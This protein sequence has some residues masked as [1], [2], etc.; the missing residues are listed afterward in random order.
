MEMEY[1]RIDSSFDIIYEQDTYEETLEIVK[2]L[3]SKLILPGNKHGVV[4]ATKLANDLN[5]LCNS[6]ENLDAMTLKHEMHNRIAEKGLRS[7][8][9]KLVSSVEEAIEFYD[10]ESLGEVVLKPIFSAGSINAKIC[11]NKQ[12]MVDYLKEQFSLK[13]D[14]GL[15]NDNILVQERINGDEYLVNT[16]S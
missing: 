1:E 9:G 7:I 13:D 8:R 2:K 15:S 14:F 5:L 10:C 4:L 3:D 12:D 11:S 6:I 16:V